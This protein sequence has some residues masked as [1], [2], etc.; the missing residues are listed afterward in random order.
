MTKFFNSLNKKRNYIDPIL[1]KTFKEVFDEIA[2]YILDIVDV[3]FVGCVS[4]R[5]EAQKCYSNNKGFKC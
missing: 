1:I 2:P 3:S 5:F 4:S